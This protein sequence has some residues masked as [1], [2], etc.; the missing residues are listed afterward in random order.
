VT[1]VCVRDL[2]VTHCVVDD[3]QRAWKTNTENSA[4][5]EVII[6]RVQADVEK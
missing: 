6:S 5:F 3:Y 1:Y 4:A 2:I